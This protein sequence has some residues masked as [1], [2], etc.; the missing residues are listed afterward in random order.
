MTRVHVAVVRNLKIAM[1]QL[2][3]KYDI[4]EEFHL[5]GVILLSKN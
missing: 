5:F 4:A 1:V 3:K 2:Y